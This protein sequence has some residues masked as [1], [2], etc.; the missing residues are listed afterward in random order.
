MLVSTPLAAALT[1]PLTAALAGITP[2][3]LLSPRIRGVYT[4]STGTGRHRRRTT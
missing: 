4:E 2:A 1:D 3:R